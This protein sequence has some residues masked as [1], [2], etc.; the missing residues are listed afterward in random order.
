MI[1]KLCKALNMPLY[2]LM[3]MEAPAPALPKDKQKLLDDLNALNAAHRDA[4]ARLV[5][6]LLAE[7]EQTERRIIRR[8]NSRVVYHDQ[9]SSAA[10]PGA[11]AP[12]YAEPE[13]VYM[14]A[15]RASERCNL[16]FKV[17]GG[18]MEPDYPNGCRVF[19]ATDE[20]TP[21]GEVGVFIIN[22]EYFIKE[23]REDR[24]FSRNRKHSDILFHE[25]MDIRHY[26]R[27]IGI[28]NEDDILEGEELDHVREAYEDKAL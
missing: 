2:D 9:L 10:G 12:D 5:L 15:S 13:I 8:C 25:D 26:G 23:R 20:E 24:L 21:V 6:R 4:V 19:V 27:V 28:V 11:S 18:S 14:R 7:Q 17:N 16:M 1:P 3:G 22:G